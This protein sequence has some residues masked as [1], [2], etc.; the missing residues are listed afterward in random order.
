MPTAFDLEMSA[1]DRGII[2]S[3]YTGVF[4][5]ARWAE[6]YAQALTP[7]LIRAN[8]QFAPHV[9]DLRGLKPSQ[10]DWV[11][12]SQKV[13]AHLVKMGESRGR[14]A[15]IVGDNPEAAMAARFFIA[16]KKAVHDRGGEPRI[17]EDFDA[18]Y[19]WAAEGFRVEA[20]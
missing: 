1:D 15:L 17:F 14:R 19:A 3:R 8:E 9:A 4:D 7:R 20:L 18:G 16:F 10:G 5:V 2:C 13:F 6:L 12:D 11:E